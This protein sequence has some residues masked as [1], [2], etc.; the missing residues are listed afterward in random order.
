[1]VPGPPEGPTERARDRPDLAT[2]PPAEHVPGTQRPSPYQPKDRMMPE[3][4]TVTS[5]Q[6]IWP[7]A[8]AAF[9]MGI[10]IGLVI[11]PVLIA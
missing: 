11:G 7:W 1:M 10:I 8:V 4:R 9:L 6:P 3:T 2:A 5:R